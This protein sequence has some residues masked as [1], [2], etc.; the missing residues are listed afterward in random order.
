MESRGDEHTETQHAG[1][2]NFEAHFRGADVWIEAG[3]DVIHAAFEVHVRIG[4]EADVGKFVDVHEGQIIFVDI[5]HDPDF[6]E[7]GDGE[8]IRRIVEGLDAGGGGD[9]L[10]DD[11][12][13][14]GRL[15]IDDGARMIEVGAQHADAFGGVFDGDFGFGLG[16]FGNFQ[17]LLRHG[18]LFVKQLGALVLS[19]GQRF[20]G[21]RAAIVGEGLRDVG[22]LDAH[23]QLIFDDG[24]AEAR[25]DVDNASGCER[26]HG[27]VARYVGRYGSGDVQ[28]GSGVVLLGGSQGKLLRMIHLH[29]IGIGFAL[30]NGS[31]RRFGF[32]VGLNF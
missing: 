20:I 26:N 6:G 7:V 3:A 21:H 31:R 12:A 9:V 17:I 5:A 32:G 4:V 29:E 18:A 23:Q 2:R 28:F 14:N 11:D 10:F 13:G 8:E 19:A 25:A 24:I 15:D 30:N 1:I 22:A 16:V 27:D